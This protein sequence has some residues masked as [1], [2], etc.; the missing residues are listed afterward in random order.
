MTNVFF[1]IKK[2]YT[3]NYINSNKKKKLNNYIIKSLIFIIRQ[4]FPLIFFF[5]FHRENMEIINCFILTQKSST[6]LGAHNP[7]L[8]CW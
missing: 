1:K 6:N 4:Q 2:K 8:A 5:T 3:T 7:S